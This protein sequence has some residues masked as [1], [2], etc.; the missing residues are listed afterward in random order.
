MNDM[1][2]PFVPGNGTVVVPPLSTIERLGENG[3]DYS[4]LNSKQ[5]MMLDHT[6]PY[7]S[8]QQPTYPPQPL[9]QSNVPIWVRNLSDDGDMSSHT[10][11]LSDDS[12]PGG[13]RSFVP[14][15][16]QRQS[17]SNHGG[18]RRGP[19]TISASETSGYLETES[20][21]TSNANSRGAY[22]GIVGRSSM[23]KGYATSIS[24]PSNQGHTVPLQH[25]S[26]SFHPLQNHP[27]ANPD[28]YRQSESGISANATNPSAFSHNQTQAY[29]QLVEQKERRTRE[30]QEAVD[31]LA[32]IHSAG[33][34][35]D[36]H[37]LSMGTTAYT[38]T[39]G[40]LVDRRAP[41][42]P[43]PYIRSPPLPD[44]P[45]P[46]VDVSVLNGGVPP[47]PPLREKAG[48]ADRKSVV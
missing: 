13:L 18:A 41:S 27:Y 6:Q 16:R 26:Q 37:R 33:T 10:G 44:A 39:D 42:A 22:S 24:S 23:E 45:V 31:E 9:R 40:G 35:E 48:W 25:L 29:A 38:Y 8:L 12:S 4:N 20:D 32:F 36:S 3:V 46:S 28:S 17:E 47:V 11:A 15:R 21:S 7:T 14:S 34:N 1:V 2:N 19:R 30:E 43:P 5:R